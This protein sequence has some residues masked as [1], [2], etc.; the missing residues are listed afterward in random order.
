VIKERGIVVTME[1]HYVGAISVVK[2]GIK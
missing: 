2:K 1:D